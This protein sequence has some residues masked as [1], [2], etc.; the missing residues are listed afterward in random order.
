MKRPTRPK[1]KRDKP[2][3]YKKYSP[4][5]AVIA[6]VTNPVFKA[7]DA[8]SGLLGKVPLPPLNGVR[9]VLKSKPLLKS[10]YSL[11]AFTLICAERAPINPKAR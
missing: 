4:T 7:L 5:T 11:K 2:L 3:T 8:F 10:K 9:F 1:G 6:N